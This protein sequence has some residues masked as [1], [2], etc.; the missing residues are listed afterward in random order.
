MKQLSD[1]IKIKPLV[2][3]ES[4]PDGWSAYDGLTGCEYW[5]TPFGSSVHWPYDQEFTPN[6]PIPTIY[7]TLD[8]YMSAC[9]AHHQNQAYTTLLRYVEVKQ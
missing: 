6:T 3:K 9:E 4:Y 7:E 1:V 2:W 5:A 8:G